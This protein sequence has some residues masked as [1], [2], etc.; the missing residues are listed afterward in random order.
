MASTREIRRRIRS[1]ENTRQITRAMEMVAATKMRRAQQ[2]V[3]ASR[4]YA[5][6]A[7]SLFEVAAAAGSD[8]KLP[9]LDVRPV[10]RRTIIMLGSDRG[11]CGAMNTNVMRMLLQ[12]AAGSP[13]RYVAVGRKSQSGLRAG[14]RDLLASFTN[15]PDALHYRDV[16]PIARVAID[17]FTSGATDQVLLAYPKFVSTISNQPTL[18]SLL[19][20]ALP[21][22][23]RPVAAAALTLFEPS[24]EVVLTELLPRVVEIR[25]WQA[26]LETR[27]SFYSSQMTAMHNATNNASDLLD[28]LRLAYN[29]IR[30]AAITTEIAEI[31]A[32]SG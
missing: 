2:A 23:E 7:T 25:I 15:L 6:A 22:T 11:L 12:D 29:Q 20:A 21:E 28:A 5:E 17:E 31:A 3:V 1:I 26:L 18:V 32:A 10:K 19:P 24:P 27:A 8:L 16:L 13:S 30:Q 14:G 9:L 4:R